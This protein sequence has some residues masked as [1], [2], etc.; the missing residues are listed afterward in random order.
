MREPD[1]LVG[2][3][4]SYLLD[5]SLGR[6]N[7]GVKV[8]QR[9]E[10]LFPASAQVAPCGIVCIRT[11]WPEPGCQASRHQI[12]SSVVNHERPADS[13]GG[14]AAAALRG[15]VTNPLSLEGEG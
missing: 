11:A 6:C 3:S 2:V 5:V 4:H 13:V 1:D 8:Q 15:C 7:M 9:A 10:A 12:H 14:C